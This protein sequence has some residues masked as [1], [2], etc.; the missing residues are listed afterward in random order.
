[1][2]KLERDVYAVQDGA[3][4]SSNKEAEMRART[5]IQEERPRKTIFNH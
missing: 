1:M 2:N 4:K 3:V 5:R